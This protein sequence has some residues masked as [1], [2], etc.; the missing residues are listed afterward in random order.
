LVIGHSPERIMPYEIEQKFRCSNLALVRKRL[1]E[2]G[3]APGETVDQADCYYRHPVRDFAQTDEAFRLRR[4]GDVNFMTY[5]G[6]KIDATTK[7]RR[8]EEVRLADGVATWKSCDEIVRRLGFES[9]AVVRKRRETLHL[10]RGDQSIEAALDDV[11][12][13]G[14]FVELEVSVDSA[15][16][17]APAVDAAKRAL[18]ELAAELELSDSERRSYLELLLAAS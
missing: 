15:G 16:D 1:L 17:D 14:T 3:A 10:E 11:A 6:P 18:A 4:V 9:V 13:V 8:E 12:D 7:S 2:L 5:K